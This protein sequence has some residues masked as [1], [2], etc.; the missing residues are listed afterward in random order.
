MARTVS[1]LAAA[2]LAVCSLSAAAAPTDP[3]V[4]DWKL[5]PEKS[6]ITDQMIVERLDGNKCT[7]NFGSIPETIVLDGT[8]QPG[9]FGTD[10]AVSIEAPD[11]WK[12]VR[13]KDG[14]VLLIGI[15]SLSSDGRTLTDDFTSYRSDGTT[16]NVKYN[17][18]R[19]GS[20]SAFT[21]TWIGTP[22]AMTS[23]VILQIRPWEQ[24]GL[25]FADSKGQ[26]T[27]NVKFDGKGYPHSG[28]SAITG[29]ISSAHRV[30]DRSIEFTDKVNGTLLRTRTVEL[31]PDRKTMTITIHIP[32]STE[33]NIQVFDRQ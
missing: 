4:G 3:F 28:P 5:N 23:P 8:D 19:S 27:N 1:I 26:D 16:N 12:V 22:E 2:V 18:K 33:P 11:K 32:S 10:L 15:W 25:S 17:Y 13:K 30:S 24:D 9:V 21:A 31:S 29:Y 14:H 7:F 20:G 6:K